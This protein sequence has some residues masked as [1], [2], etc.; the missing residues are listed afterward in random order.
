MIER[1][2]TNE[3]HF[4]RLMILSLVLLILY[5][6]LG[7]FTIGSECF[8]TYWFQMNVKLSCSLCH[9]TDTDLREFCLHLRRH[10]SDPYFHVD[11]PMCRKKFTTVRYW[12]DHVL[13]RKCSPVEAAGCAS[14]APETSSSQNQQETGVEIDSDSGD[15]VEDDTGAND[16]RKKMLGIIIKIREKNVTENR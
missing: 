2:I 15:K 14:N 12:K 8:C 10:G 7:E 13:S 16:V 1:I 9:H 4:L 5:A 6:W 11:C 3:I